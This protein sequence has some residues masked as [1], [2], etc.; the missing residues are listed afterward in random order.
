MGGRGGGGR[1]GADRSRAE[2]PA[3]DGVVPGMPH[4]IQ[5]DRRSDDLPCPSGDGD[6]CA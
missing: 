3:A 6:D 2:T 4:A 5:G 1:R